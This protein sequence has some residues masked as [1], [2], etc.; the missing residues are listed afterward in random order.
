VFEE[1]TVNWN[2][3]LT[4]LEPSVTDTVTGYWAKAC[5]TVGVQETTP[6]D[7]STVMPLGPSTKANVSFCTGKS[8]SLATRRMTVGF[9]GSMVRLS[10]DANSGAW[11]TSNTTIEKAFVPLSTGIPLSVTRTTTVLVL[12][13][14]AS[15]GRNDT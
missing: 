2:E 3:V 5:S 13:P 4:E 7:E 15:V 8:A 11:L 12:G 9:I 1:R 10:T 6:S 14:W